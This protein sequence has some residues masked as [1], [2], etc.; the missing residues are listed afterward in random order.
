MMPV[1]LPARVRAAAL[2]DSPDTL[3][4]RETRA[5]LAEVRRL[6]APPPPRDPRDPAP[7]QA[8]AA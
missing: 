6:L 7:S 2:W 1:R 8:R 3:R 4:P 5:L